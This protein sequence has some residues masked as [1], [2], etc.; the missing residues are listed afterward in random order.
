MEE[1]TPEPEVEVTVNW[2]GWSFTAVQ[3]DSRLVA[4][5]AEPALQKLLSER[6]VTNR[7]RTWAR[8]MSEISSQDDGFHPR[9]SASVKYFSESEALA[10]VACVG[11][12]RAGALVRELGPAFGQ[13]QS[14]LDG[15]LASLAGVSLPSG[16][17]IVGA[18][19]S[20][21][22]FEARERARIISALEST[23]WHKGNAADKLGI[24]RRTLFRRLNKYGIS[25]RPG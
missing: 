24:P 6:K 1:Q 14:T 12:P 16:E 23:G 18:P 10:V 15:W 8:V 22:E 4:C 20:E 7:E 17:S 25:R 11:G 3:T 9:E 2:E 21:K 19:Q 5:L 13:A